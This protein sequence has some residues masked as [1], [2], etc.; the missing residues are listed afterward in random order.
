MKEVD[1]R[2]GYFGYFM[3]RFV[4][5][6]DPV[7]LRTPEEVKR[8]IPDWLAV[9]SERRKWKFPQPHMYFELAVNGVATGGAQAAKAGS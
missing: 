5:L 7:N 1:R 6:A 9:V 4:A 2:G 3:D 8:L